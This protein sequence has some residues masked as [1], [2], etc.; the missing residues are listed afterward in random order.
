MSWLWLCDIL[1]GSLSLS[2]DATS[3]TIWSARFIRVRRALVPPARNIG[4]SQLM[5]YKIQAL[6]LDRSSDSDTG[7]FCGEFTRFLAQRLNQLLLSTLFSSREPTVAPCSVPSRIHRVT[8][9][10]GGAYPLDFR[11]QLCKPW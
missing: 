7:C 1:V 4:C 5:S 9:F 11:R 6:P 2:S 3:R 10:T 8:R